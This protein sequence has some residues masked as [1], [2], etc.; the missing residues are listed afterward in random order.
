MV[1]N[2]E[3]C[4]TY[5][6]SIL[7]HICLTSHDSPDIVIQSPGK[8]KKVGYKSFKQPQLWVNQ[9]KQKI[10]NSLINF[11][12]CTYLMQETTRAQAIEE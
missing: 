7:P 3:G 4:V 12:D 11:A 8:K 6:P 1:T 10:I 9:K 5:L 2:A